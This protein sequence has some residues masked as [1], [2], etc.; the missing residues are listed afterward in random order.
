[1]YLLSHAPTPTLPTSLFA[2]PTSTDKI[3]NFSLRTGTINVIMRA[4]RRAEADG[5]C[6]VLL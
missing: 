3:A 5:F 2:P 1:M 6:F 4:N